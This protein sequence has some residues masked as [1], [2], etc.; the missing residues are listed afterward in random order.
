MYRAIALVENVV[1]VS[2]LAFFSV[3]IVISVGFRY[4]L[5]LPLSWTEEASLIA[6]SWLLFIGAAI[7]ARENAHVLIDLFAPEPGSRAGR[8]SD[9]FAALLGAAVSLVMAWVGYRYTVGAAPMVTPIFRISS[10]VYN[11]AAP[12]GFALIALHLGVQAARAIRP[13]GGGR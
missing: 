4:L 12:V 11:A 6:F 7:A 1:A 10:A 8:L 9:G 2:A 13:A 3:F 5:N